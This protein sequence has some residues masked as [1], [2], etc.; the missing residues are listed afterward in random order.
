[1]NLH[2]QSA[3]GVA[4]G[5]GAV[6]AQQARTHGHAP[7]LTY[8]DD[9]SGERT[10]LSYATFDNWVS[11]SANLLAEEAGAGPGSTLSLGL[12][13]HWIGAVVVAAAWKLGAVIRTG[14]DDAA[15]IVVVAEDDRGSV[16]GGH[17]GLVVVGGGMGGRVL[18]DGPGL[19]YGAEVLAFA[20][21]YDDPR[22]TM[23]SPAAATPDGVLTHGEVYTAVAGGLPAD[24]RLLVARRLDDGQPRLAMAVC[25]GASLVWCP[26]SEATDLTRRAADERV[27]HRLGDDGSI[28]PA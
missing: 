24:A 22:V 20:D 13:D 1:M 19:D 8:Y 28:Q 25:A 17:P 2:R 26:R 18:E 14:A 21:D 16:R 27:T 12:V 4:R 3:A 11:K 7:F 9:R 6:L 10:E 23:D 15:D 5:L